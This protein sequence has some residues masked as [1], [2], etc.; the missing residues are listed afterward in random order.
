MPL[1]DGRQLVSTIALRQALCD[2]PVLIMSGVVG[3]TRSPTCWTRRLAF[4]AKP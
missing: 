3:V 4:L 1:L 2:L